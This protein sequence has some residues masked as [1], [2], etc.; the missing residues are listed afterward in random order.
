MNV[1]VSASTRFGGLHMTSY[2]KGDRK[3]ARSWH[4]VEFSLAEADDYLRQGRFDL[5]LESS[6][7]AFL[8]LA[9]MWLDVQGVA[10]ARSARVNIIDQLRHAGVSGQDWA[11]RIGQYSRLR[12]RVMAG[13]DPLFFQDAARA[14]YALALELRESIQ[15]GSLSDTESAA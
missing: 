3:A 14:V 5:A 13:Y 10:K 7:R 1:V 6:Y 8:R 2:A 4:S 11:E 9:G 15:I 12:S